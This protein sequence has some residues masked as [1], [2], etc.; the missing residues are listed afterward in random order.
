MDSNHLGQINNEIEEEK[1]RKENFEKNF[2]N[3]FAEIFP[4]LEL[5]SHKSAEVRESMLRR[6]NLYLHLYETLIDRT[7]DEIST[8]QVKTLT[9]INR[10]LTNLHS[11]YNTIEFPIDDHLTNSMIPVGDGAISISID[12]LQQIFNELIEENTKIVNH[13]YFNTNAGEEKFKAREA[14]AIA[15]IK[16]SLCNQFIEIVGEDFFTDKDCRSKYDY[17][18]LSSLETFISSFFRIFLGRNIAVSEPMYDESHQSALRQFIKGYLK[19]KYP[20]N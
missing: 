5:D 10:L 11:L 1:A 13:P 6:T 8:D 9:K 3:F 12:N 18:F 7:R 16:K 17:D 20:N 19:E 15:H 2:D 4:L 14:R